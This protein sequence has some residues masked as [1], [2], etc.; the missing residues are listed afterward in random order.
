MPELTATEPKVVVPSLNVTVPVGLVPVTVAVS[1]TACPTK[2]GLG[3]A[4][5]ET[6][7]A[8]FALT[9]SDAALEVLVELLVSPP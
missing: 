6:D 7:V 3:L 8:V 2:A 5:S 9:L 1:T 4:A